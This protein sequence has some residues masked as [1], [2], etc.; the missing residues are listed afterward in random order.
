[1]DLRTDRS[2]WE[3][4][5]DPE[6]RMAKD[7]SPL[8]DDL[9]RFW[10]RNQTLFSKKLNE[11]RIEPLPS[12]ALL[13]NNFEAAGYRYALDLNTKKSPNDDLALDVMSD[14][15]LHLRSTALGKKPI[16]TADKKELGTYPPIDMA[17]A[18]VFRSPF[19]N[20]IAVVLLN[21]ERGWEGPPHT[22]YVTIVGAD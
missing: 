3:Y 21:V 7:G 14:A 16:Y 18:G 22:V 6:K 11:Y 1:V 19:E 12:F 4:K 8:P 5:N 9:R 13:A 17:V 20:R 15:P 10:K 2:L